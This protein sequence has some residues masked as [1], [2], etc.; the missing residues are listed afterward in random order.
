MRHCGNCGKI[1]HNIRTCSHFASSTQRQERR[2]ERAKENKKRGRTASTRRCGWCMRLGHNQRT[3]D[4]YAEAASQYRQLIYVYRRAVGDMMAER[5][6]GVGA[7]ICRPGAHGDHGDWSDISDKDLLAKASGEM[8]GHDLFLI[9]EIRWE[10]I[11]PGPLWRGP[12]QCDNPA[13]RGAFRGVCVATK[14]TDGIPRESWAKV[15]SSYNPGLPGDTAMKD[16]LEAKGRRYQLGKLYPKWFVASPTASAG[17]RS[18][19]P[20]GWISGT[21]L[22]TD[23]LIRSSLKGWAKLQKDC[24]SPRFSPATTF[25]DK[26]EPVLDAYRHAVKKGTLRFLPLTNNLGARFAPIYK[27]Y[28]DSWK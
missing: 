4:V 26:L 6:V 20:A 27:K 3:C 1:G 22:K 18:A 25:Q 28:E 19:S 11:A 15:R 23:A 10:H 24:R 17:W 14:F 2:A 8:Q 13:G 16:H 12:S 7:L 21:D 5:G 9:K